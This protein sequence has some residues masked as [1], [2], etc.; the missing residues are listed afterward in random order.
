HVPHTRLKQPT[1]SSVMFTYTVDESKAFRFHFV[2]ISLCD[3]NFDTTI[4]VLLN[5]LGKLVLICHA[6][7]GSFLQE[8][9][10][11]RKEKEK[12]HVFLRRQLSLALHTF[13]VTGIKKPKIKKVI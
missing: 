6:L 12:L 9:G 3:D 13:M 10:K 4:I 11:K 8:K 1:G 2:L 7:S 5:I